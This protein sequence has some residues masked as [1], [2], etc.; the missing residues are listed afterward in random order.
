MS[1]SDVTDVITEIHQNL[2]LVL[3]DVIPYVRF[4]E[5]TSDMGLQEFGPRLLL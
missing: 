3:A 2:T 4:A 5:L 1:D